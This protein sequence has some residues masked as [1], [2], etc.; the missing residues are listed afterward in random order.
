MPVDLHLHS[1]ASDGSDTPSRVVELA[2]AAGLETIA[3][4]DHDNLFG[5]TEAAQR[6]TE[7]GIGFIPG[8]EL[9][10]GWDSSGTVHLLVY[11]LKPGPGPL[12]DRLTWLQEGR[13]KRNQQIAQR[14]QE[15]GLDITLDDVIAEAHGGVVGRPHFAAVMVAKGYVTDIRSAFD[16]FLATGRPAYTPRERLNAPE[17]IRL[18]IESGAVPVIAHPHTIGISAEEYGQAFQRLAE[19][20]VGGIEA[21]Y[22]EYTPEQRAHIAE[23]CKKLDLVATGGSD[24]HGSYKPGLAVGVGKGDLHV[25]NETVRALAARRDSSTKRPVER[26]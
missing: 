20:G 12:Q 25:P 16:R 14:L 9:S 26:R 8:T 11:Y 10:V 5:V 7:L 1:S 17:A 22:A 21:H 13:A 15:L 23:L 4:T 24:Y 6:A 19:I 2:A 18:A 3:L